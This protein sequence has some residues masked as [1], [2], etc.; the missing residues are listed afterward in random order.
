MVKA[1]K[2][3]RCSTCESIAS[4]VEKLY[5]KSAPLLLGEALLLGVVALFMA[6]KPLATLATLMFIWG[7]D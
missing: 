1:S 7:V 3:A 2:K 5:H 4:S 6:F